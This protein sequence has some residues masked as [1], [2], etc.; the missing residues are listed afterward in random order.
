MPEVKVGFPVAEEFSVAR[1]TDHVWLLRRFRALFNHV[2]SPGRHDS[3]YYPEP[4]PGNEVSSRNAAGQWRVQAFLMN[5]EVRYSFYLRLL[6][7]W[8]VKDDADKP[9]THDDSS[10]GDNREDDGWAASWPLPPWDVALVFYIHMLSPERFRKDMAAEYP[11]LWHAR[12][13]FP[14]ARLRQHPR[15]HEASQRKWETMFP[16]IP[17]RLFEFE[18]DGETPRLSTSIGR[19]LDVRG[20]KC[21]SDDCTA[22]TRRNRCRIIIP[23]AEW[24]AYRLGK[25][26]SP[27]CPSCRMAFSSQRAGYNS[28]FARFCEA[29]FGQHVLGLW[30][31]PL[32]QMAFVDRILAETT[33]ATATTTNTAAG[34]SSTTITFSPAQVPAWQ[35]RY[36]KFL[37]LI[38]AHRSTTF[39]PTL[40]IDLVWHTHQLAP[41]AYDA[42]CRAHVGHPVNHDDTIPAAGR[43][44]ALDDTK[45][46]WTLAYRELYLDPDSGDGDGGGGGGGGPGAQ[47]EEEK[48]KEESGAAATRNGEGKKGG[49]WTTTQR[50][51][52][53]RALLLLE[54]VAELETCLADRERRLAA[55]DGAGTIET[56]RA[57]AE[58]NRRRR[59]VE[60]NRWTRLRDEHST[61]AG[62]LRGAKKARDGV[63]PLL[64]VGRWWRWYPRS[65]R[66]ELARRE[67]AVREVEARARAKLD[68]VERQRE[69]ADE[70]AEQSRLA[71]ERLRR[72]EADRV[73][74][75][76]ELDGRVIAAEKKLVRDCIR[77]A[78]QL[79]GDPL[80]EGMLSVVPSEAQIRPAPL[81]GNWD[82]ET[83]TERAWPVRCWGTRPGAGT[84]ASTYHSTWRPDREGGGSFGGLAFGSDVYGSYEG[85]GGD[86]WGGSGGGG[87]GGGGGGSSGGGCGGGGG[88]ASE[89]LK[90][91]SCFGLLLMFFSLRHHTPEKNIQGDL[92]GRFI[93]SHPGAFGN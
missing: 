79:R 52:N 11:P 28:A 10:D 21:G 82:R 93:T 9:D 55:F 37:G 59:L 74:L 23:M 30:D 44:T 65:R 49:E 53:V 92:K 4:P 8:V 35:A 87:D 54:R 71:D 86:G 17:Y 57:D 3:N 61:L 38:K 26:R 81:V 31:A 67:A 14:L 62:A 19:P 50:M 13:S 58:R 33:T 22:N 40:D 83:T 7:E 25:R 66:E 60:H 16:D 27:T 24:S 48:K 64:R 2:E 76:V 18:P 68:E 5:A 72:A 51:A 56:R 41:A 29:V 75:E 36:L 85:C 88:G 47:A 34:G 15:G 80:G 77:R 42:Y 45:R 32:R 84:A 12:L 78:D 6:R 43:S 63:R 89:P 20:Y 70:A 90:F 91:P 69:V 1:I 73:R 39:V 46:L